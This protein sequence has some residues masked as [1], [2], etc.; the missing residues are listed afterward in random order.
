MNVSLGN[1]EGREAKKHI[2]MVVKTFPNFQMQETVNPFIRNMNKITPR[3]ILNKLMQNINKDKI[4]KATR[5]KKTHYLQR[6][7]YKAVRRIF[8]RNESSEKITKQ[9]FQRTKRKK[10]C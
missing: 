9:Y 1:R 4:I 6:N 8:I 5:G 3:H 10:L 2:E 7:N